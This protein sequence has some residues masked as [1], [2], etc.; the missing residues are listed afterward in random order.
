MIGS[1]SF[2]AFPSGRLVSEAAIHHPPAIVFNDSRHPPANSSRKSTPSL[3]YSGV[4]AYGHH[5]AGMTSGALLSGGQSAMQKMPSRI[6]V[7]VS[8]SSSHTYGHNSRNNSGNSSRINSIS[9]TV[10][11]PHEYDVNLQQVLTFLH[12]LGRVDLR[13]WYFSVIP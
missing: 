10:P 3:P 11:E 12:I 2:A 13:Q 5:S 1:S 8:S 6:I 9:R 7:P 4:L